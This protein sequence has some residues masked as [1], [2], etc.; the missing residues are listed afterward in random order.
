MLCGGGVG[1]YMLFQAISL[2]VYTF[3]YQNNVELLK[4]VILLYASWKYI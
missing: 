4:F 3:N 1:H 2:H